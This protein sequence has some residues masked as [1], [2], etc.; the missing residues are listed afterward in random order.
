VNRAAELIKN[1]QPDRAL[2]I[3]SR[4]L[5]A[6]PTG[7]DSVTAFYHVSEALLERADMTN[8]TEPRQRACAILGSLRNARGTTYAESITF[9]F[10]QYCK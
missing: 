3:L 10:N 4:A 1:R 2:V 6:L 7:N 5:K 9:M 8:T